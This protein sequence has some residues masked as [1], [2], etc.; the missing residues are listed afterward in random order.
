M[1]RLT[2]DPAMALAGAIWVAMAAA[3]VY[4]WA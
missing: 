1:N 2:I 3:L 4:F